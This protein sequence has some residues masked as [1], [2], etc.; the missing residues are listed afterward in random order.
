[1]NLNF[2]D[3]TNFPA[4]LKEKRLLKNLKQKELSEMLGYG[5]SYIS[6]LETGKTSPSLSV[7]INLASVLDVSIDYLLLGSENAKYDNLDTVISQLSPTERESLATTIQHMLNHKK[8][9]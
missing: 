3:I 1:M 4:R 8:D 6:E 9:D 7:L 2:E 5:Q